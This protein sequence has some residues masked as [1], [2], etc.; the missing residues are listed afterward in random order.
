MYVGIRIHLYIKM[1][2]V[3]CPRPNPT[4]ASYNASVVNIYIAESS[5]VRFENKKYFLQI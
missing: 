1:V 5:L 4:I 2:A 3:F